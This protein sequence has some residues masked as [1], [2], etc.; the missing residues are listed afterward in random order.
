MMKRV[1]ILV[2]FMSLALGVATAQPGFGQR[3]RENHQ[4]RGEMHEQLNLT[5]A[6]E[7]A[8][9]KLRREHE[10]RI[11]QLRSKIQETRIDMRGQLESDTPDRGTIEKAIRTISDLQLQMKLATNELHFAMRELLTPEQR[12]LAK[13]HR[14]KMGKPGGPRRQMRHHGECDNDCDD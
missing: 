3:H 6:Q 8:M 12:E 5:D 13:E 2:V 1:G 7:V 11:V 9:G 10:K 14:Q 4:F